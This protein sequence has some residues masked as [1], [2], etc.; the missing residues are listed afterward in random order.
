MN[1]RWL[2]KRKTITTI[3]KFKD[4]TG[5][6]LWQPS[7]QGGQPDKLLNVPAFMSEHAPNTFT[8]GLYVGIIGDFYIARDSRQQYVMDC[9]PKERQ[10]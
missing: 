1:A 10:Q 7:V 5:Q 4:T 9:L 6:Y 8:T 2:S 3:R